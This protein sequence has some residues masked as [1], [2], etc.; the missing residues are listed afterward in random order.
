MTTNR[1]HVKWICAELLYTANSKLVSFQGHNRS[2]LRN[3]LEKIAHLVY[4]SFLIIRC[5]RLK[6]FRRSKMKFYTLTA[7]S[8]WLNSHI[9][10]TEW[11]S[12]NFI[13]NACATEV[14]QV[15]W[16]YYTWGAIFGLDL[17][18]LKTI[19]EV[20]WIWLTNL[21]AVPE[22]LWLLLSCIKMSFFNSELLNV[23][24]TIKLNILW[25]SVVL[26]CKLKKKR[27]HSAKFSEIISMLWWAPR[28]FLTV[29]RI[30]FEMTRSCEN[31]K[32]LIE[33]RILSLKLWC[34]TPTVL[35]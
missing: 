6:G 20:P 12:S 25:M 14:K 8:F 16:S 13:W 27:H 18:Q 23:D 4:L 2:L 11:K 34:L 10:A 35:S 17:A 15:S 21:A 19:S 1:F 22:I 26:W 24:S 3:P 30:T 7:I 9:R 5:T 33:D 32:N 28:P 31:F 29:S